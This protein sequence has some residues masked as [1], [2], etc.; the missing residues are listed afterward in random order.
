MLVLQNQRNVKSRDNDVYFLQDNIFIILTKINRQ[1]DE[2]YKYREVQKDETHYQQIH[3]KQVK[4]EL[5]NK[6]WKKDKQ[7][8]IESE[9][10]AGSYSF[11]FNIVYFSA[12]FEQ[13]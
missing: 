1:T 8:I 5:I 13:W 12:N 4:L 7:K 3:Q 2:V 11:T 10:I 9:D 6:Y